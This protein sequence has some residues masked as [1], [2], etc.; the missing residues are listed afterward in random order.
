MSINTITLDEFKE[1]CNY[2]ID[3]N[4]RLVDEE[5]KPTAICLEGEAGIGKTESVM[6]IARNRGMTIV[7][8]NLAEIEEPADMLG[9][10]LKEYKLKVR[11][12]DDTFKEEWVAHD[13]LDLYLRSA[14]EDFQLT[15]D[16]RMSY[17][18]PAWLPREENPNGTIIFLDDFSRANSIILAC[19]LE[20]INTGKYISWK[21]PKYTQIVLSSNP[22]NGMYQVTGLDPAMQSRMVNFPI[23]FDINGWARWA[24]IT[25]LDGRAINFAL[26]YSHEL[27]DTENK[28]INPRSYTTFCNAISGLNNWDETKSLAMILNIAKGCFDDK[29]NVVGNLF[30]MFIA[31]KLDKLVEPEKMLMGAWD[32][33]KERVKECVYTENG[34]YRPDIASVLST[35]LLNYISYYFD[36]QGS[37]SDI[38]QKRLLEFIDSDIMLFS[39]DLIYN[40]V[41]QLATNYASKMN[42]VIIHPKIRKRLL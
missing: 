21:L 9:F 29:N 41:K 34:N 30:T 39:E 32:T 17:A 35:R 16:V 10:P 5:K 23:K 24:E 40:V 33:V 18:T 13:L 27:F 25:Q 4:K 19:I 20:L 8:L 1:I 42:K 15:G 11:Q 38:V 22:D 7:K 26:Q 37:K 3:N 14:C 31:N 6:E 2:L 28:T 36:Q 12:K